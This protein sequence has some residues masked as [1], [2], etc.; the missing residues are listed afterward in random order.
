[1]VVPT[2][3]Q[4]SDDAFTTE[5]LDTLRSLMTDL[6]TTCAT[7]VQERAPH[8]EWQPVITDAVGQ[9]EQASI[10]LADLARSL[11]TTRR[12]IGAL[13]RQARQRLHGNT[14]HPG[15]RSA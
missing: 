2:T 9:F 11:N 7:V 4:L 8:G 14:G 13:D 15:A 5:E 3:Q 12:A 6:I 1:M 10:V